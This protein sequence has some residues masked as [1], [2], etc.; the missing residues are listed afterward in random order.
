MKMVRLIL[1]RFLKKK[2]A[3]PNQYFILKSENSV[4]TYYNSI[5]QAI[6]K[7]DKRPCFRRVKPRN[8][9]QTFAIHAIMN[10]EVKLVTIQGVAGTGKT[11]LDSFSCVLLEQRRMFKQVYLARPTVPLSNKDIGYLP[12]DIKSKLNPYMEPLLG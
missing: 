4:L 1:K 11:L 7:V 8:A 10:P 6:E 3:L 2:K 5:D 12:G 9:E